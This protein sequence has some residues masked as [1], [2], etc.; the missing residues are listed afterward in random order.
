MI[1]NSSSAWVRGLLEMFAAEGVDIAH[2]MRHTRLDAARLADAGSRFTTDEV[3]D[4][5]LCALRLSRNP[6]LGLDLAHGARH[7]DFEE[8]GFAMLA[9]PHLVC[10]LEEFARYLDLVSSATTFSVA[11][12]T[13]GA[14]IVMGHTG[15]TRPVPPQRSAYSLLALLAMCRWIT[16]E[17]ILP[18]Q[19][20]FGFSE[21]ERPAAYAHAFGCPVTFGHADHRMFIATKDLLATIPSCNAALLAIHEHALEDR[22]AALRQD[23]ISP[24]VADAITDLLPHGEPRREQVA[25]RLAM[26]DRALQLRLNAEH[27][28]FLH[29]LNE[30]RRTLAERHLRDGRL[31]IGQLTQRL[32]FADESNFFRACR[33]WFGMS[34]RQYREQPHDGVCAQARATTTR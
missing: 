20:Q 9:S 15:M 17:P 14:W 18:R 16:R 2:L 11:H 1:P 34:P 3:T 32:G 21:P 13:V 22:V 4:L 5:W 29:I 6:A 10:G 24:R 28:T 23:R 33:R 7:I 27:V 26:S 19:V 30:T 12:E 31:S 8:L 25:Q